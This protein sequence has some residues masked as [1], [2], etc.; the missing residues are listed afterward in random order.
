MVNF[1]AGLM[2]V[3][4]FAGVPLAQSDNKPV[5]LFAQATQSDNKP[6][7][8]FAQAKTTERVRF[9]KGQSSTNLTRNIPANGE[10]QFLINAK[11][12]QKM[13]YEVGYDFRGSDVQV[14]L[15]D[16]ASNE[17][18]ADSEAGLVESFVVRKSGD[19]SFV[20]RNKTGK[21]IQIRLYVDIQ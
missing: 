13:E 8:L 19:T 16:I 14:F 4:G 3:V 15:F 1:L 6:V 18:V 21:R 11:K 12:G 7:Q 9:A 5:Q 17:I 2:V 10:I 20:V